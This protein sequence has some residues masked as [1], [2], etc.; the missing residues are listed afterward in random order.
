MDIESLT[1]KQIR[2][3]ASLVGGC[4]RFASHSLKTG[5]AVLIRTVTFY[6][7]G[8]IAKITDT[9]IV[10][11][12]AAWIADTGRFSQALNTGVLGEI[13]PYPHG[14]TV[15]RSCVLDVSP[16]KHALPRETK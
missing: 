7:T 12:D 9:D 1:L 3:V 13:E 14:V 16:W 15:F 10:L 4:E 5:D 2:E 8:R 11:E 6:Y